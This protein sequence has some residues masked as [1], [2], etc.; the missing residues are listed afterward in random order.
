M[1]TDARQIAAT[2]LQQLGGSR[3]VA[4]TGAHNLQHGVGMHSC[5]ALYLR[6]RGSLRFN[7]LQVSLDGRDTYTVRFVKMAG[8]ARGFGTLAETT[9]EGVYAEDLRSLFER[10]TGL[11]TSLTAC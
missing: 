5:G 10:E 4:M 1:A 3:F 11:A 2:I 8:A 7:S 6:F 9:H